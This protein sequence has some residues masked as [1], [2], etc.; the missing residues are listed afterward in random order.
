MVLFHTLGA[1]RNPPEL[2]FYNF[3]R[4]NG[5]KLGAKNRPHNF[6]ACV[7][8]SP[9]EAVGCSDLCKQVLASV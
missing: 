4:G 3:K 2:H 8:I 5:G 6:V 1:P 9:A 7:V